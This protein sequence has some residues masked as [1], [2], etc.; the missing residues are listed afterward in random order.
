MGSNNNGRSSPNF[1]RV[2]PG[3]HD[4]KK[5]LHL[6]LVLSPWLLLSWYKYWLLL[7]W[8]KYRL[9]L[10]WYKYRSMGFGDWGRNKPTM[11]HIFL[12]FVCFVPFINATFVVSN[13]TDH[14][15][16]HLKSKFLELFRNV[17]LN[18]QYND[19]KAIVD[20]RGN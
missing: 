15:R 8:Y 1:W 5:C 9:L 18:K 16:H 19:H 4:N 10:S 7:S 13:S 17:I 14:E 3:P 12:Y 20:G 2:E 6:L 11:L